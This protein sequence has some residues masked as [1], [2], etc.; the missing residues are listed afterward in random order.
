MPLYFFAGVKL[1]IAGV[2]ASFRL[3]LMLSYFSRGTT[4]YEIGARGVKS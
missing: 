4:T 2:N 3:A 1:A